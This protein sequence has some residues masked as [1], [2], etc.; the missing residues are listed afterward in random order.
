VFTIGPTALLRLVKLVGSFSVS[1][2]W[3]TL[4]FSGTSRKAA[5]E[6]SRQ[7]SVGFFSLFKRV[8]PR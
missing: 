6:E 4:A 5:G 7:H 3:A 1:P 8:T 2:D